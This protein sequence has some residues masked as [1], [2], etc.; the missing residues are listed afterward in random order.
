M[1][2]TTYCSLRNYYFF[3]FLNFF[4]F[5][6]SRLISRIFR[7]IANKNDI[8]STSISIIPFRLARNSDKFSP[9]L[10]EPTYFQTIHIMRTTT[11][12][13]KINKILSVRSNFFHLLLFRNRMRIILL[14][15]MR[16]KSINIMNAIH[17]F[18]GS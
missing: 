7:I 3:L 15:S 12:V 6:F 2:S 8:G 13:Y 11:I 17:L 10:H 18:C 16:R 5:F 14:L 4:V 1:V 9:I